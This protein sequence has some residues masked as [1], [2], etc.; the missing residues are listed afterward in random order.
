MRRL[1]TSNRS[2]ALDSDVDPRLVAGGTALAAGPV[3]WG[4]AE[5]IDPQTTSPQEREDRFLRDAMPYM[6]LRQRA[7]ELHLQGYTAREM[8]DVDPDLAEALAEI[9]A[10]GAEGARR[11]SSGPSR[12]QRP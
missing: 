4:T 8:Q 1:W 2:S 12:E 6:E 10:G 7:L 3:A 5:L 11:L 9:E